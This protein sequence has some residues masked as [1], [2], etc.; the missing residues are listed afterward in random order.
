VDAAILSIPGNLMAQEAGFRELISCIDQEWIELQGTVNVTDQLV[1]SDPALVE[2]FIRA[3]LKGFIHFRDQRAQ[4][5]AIL[6]RFLR[7]KEDASAKIYD[8]MRPSLA[9]DGTVSEEIQR[10]SLEHVVD[11]AG[12]KEPPSWRRF[13]TTRWL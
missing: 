9:Q 10:K 13:S 2:R 7:T 5:I 1:A 4:T 11:R 6:T 8:L 12:L 3:T